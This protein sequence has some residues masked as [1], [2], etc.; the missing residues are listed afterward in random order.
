MSHGF[1]R[2]L[3]N[4][5]VSLSFLSEQ[6]YIQDFQYY[7]EREFVVAG[8][9]E[10]HS[11]SRHSRLQQKRASN[12]TPCAFHLSNHNLIKNVSL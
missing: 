6:K 8:V 3:R 7:Q 5:Q 9:Q 11:P 10:V 4:S 12:P 1:K 2:S